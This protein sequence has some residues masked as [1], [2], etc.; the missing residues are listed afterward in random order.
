MS[1]NSL[2]R[3]N[4]DLILLSILEDSPKYGLEIISEANLRTDGYFSFK[5]GSLYPAL[6]R[7]EKAKLVKAEF[8]PSDSG[9]PRR[10]Y[11]Y[12]TEAGKKQLTQKR[13]EFETFNSKVRALWGM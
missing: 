3:G 1:D 11:Y 2:L 4:L 13:A 7:L 10:R 9:G 5:E 6:H 12:L 8:A